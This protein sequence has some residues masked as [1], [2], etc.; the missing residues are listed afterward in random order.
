MLISPCHYDGYLDPTSV[1]NRIWV[2]RLELVGVMLAVQDC[3]PVH[4]WNP[5]VSYHIQI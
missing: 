2:M 1:E 5:V 4:C 3:C